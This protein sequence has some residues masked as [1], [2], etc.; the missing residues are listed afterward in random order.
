MRHPLVLIWIPITAVPLPLP[1]AEL[2]PKILAGLIGS[3]LVEYLSLVT[4]PYVRGRKEI[5]WTD[6]QESE[7]RF[8][9]TSVNTKIL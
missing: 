8:A 6:N 1:P 9:I 5:T 7:F 2:Y 3:E 4:V